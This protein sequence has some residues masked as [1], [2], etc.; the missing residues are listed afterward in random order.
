MRFS[1]YV[2]LP[3]D[4]TDEKAMPNTPELGLEWK[5]SDS[6]L[7]APKYWPGTVVPARETVSVAN[8]PETE[9]EPCH[10]R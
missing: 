2:A 5:S 8:T 4:E 7:T 9:P 6:E 10:Q 3:V 1:K